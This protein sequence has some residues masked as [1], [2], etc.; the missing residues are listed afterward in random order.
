MHKLCV[1]VHVLFPWGCAPARFTCGAHRLSGCGVM[2]L[3]SVMCSG[4]LAIV[5]L[6]NLATGPDAVVV[7]AG[8]A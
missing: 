2:H 4:R 6:L 5:C 7:V 3:W 8:R 1:H